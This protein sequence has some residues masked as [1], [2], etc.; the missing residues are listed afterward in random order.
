METVAKEYTFHAGVNHLNGTT[1]V[2]YVRQASLTEEGRVLRQQNVIRAILDKISSQ[3]LLTNPVTM[4]R[5]MN[6]LVT[7]LTLDSN[8]TNPEVM[9]LAAD[10][11][12]LSGADGTFVTAPTYNT[13]RVVSISTRPR[14]MSS[15]PRSG[16][17]R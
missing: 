14:A 10:L 13:F 8:F 4:Y 1:A 15:G 5:V 12:H 6:A 7:M 3:H 9:K 11:D 2:Y 17:T 16:T